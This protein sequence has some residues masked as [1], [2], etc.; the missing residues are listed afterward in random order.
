MDQTIVPRLHMYTYAHCYNDIL[1]TKHQEG[2]CAL[3]LA[4]K[5]GYVDVMKVLI[6]RG[7]DVNTQNKVIM[8]R[9]LVSCP[10]PGEYPPDKRVRLFSRSY[11]LHKLHNN[12]VFKH[13]SLIPMH[14]CTTIHVYR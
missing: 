12:H 4:A 3:S 9:S 1:Y 2:R 5:R 7:A 14:A 8:C 13:I 6:E 10:D 11:R